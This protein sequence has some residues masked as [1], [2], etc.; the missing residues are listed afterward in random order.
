M[1]ISK[2]PKGQRQTRS[3]LKVIPDVE[4]AHH[5]CHSFCA[6]GAAAWRS[7]LY[8]P[9]RQAIGELFLAGLSLAGRRA[10]NESAPD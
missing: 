5:S 3:R 9:P 1:A 2:T 8:S 6:C 4:T 10:Q 7:V